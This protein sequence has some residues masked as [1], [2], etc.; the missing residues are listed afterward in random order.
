MSR[1]HD[2]IGAEHGAVWHCTYDALPRRQVGLPASPR[3]AALPS[4]L[5]LGFAYPL[6]RITQFYHTFDF[7]LTAFLF[8][9]WALMLMFIF[10]KM[11]LFFD[12]GM[13]MFLNIQSAKRKHGNNASIWNC[14]ACCTPMVVR[15]SKNKPKYDMIPG[16]VQCKKNDFLHYMSSSLCRTD[17]PH[18]LHVQ[19]SH[20]T[21]LL[22]CFFILQPVQNSN[23]HMIDMMTAVTFIFKKQCNLGMKTSV[24]IKP[25]ESSV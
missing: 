10:L 14:L 19:W 9:F 7:L 18:C 2:C 8:R 13:S 15:N 3:P 22:S 6:L 1:G 25:A 17:N 21:F 11:G 12:T 4:H 20:H 16:S 24:G 23:S 5:I